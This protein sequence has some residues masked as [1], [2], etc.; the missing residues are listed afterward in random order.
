MRGASRILLALARRYEG[1]KAGRTGAAGRPVMVDYEKFLAESECADG[2]ARQAAEHDLREAAGR[3]LLKLVPHRRDPAIMESIRFEHAEE[4]ALFSAVGLASPAA[5]RAAI[6]G[7]FRQA[8]SHPIPENFRTYWIDYLRGKE[9]AALAGDSIAPFDR[10]DPNGNLEL[11]MLVPKLLAW[12]EES[13]VRFASCVL[14]GNSKRLEELAPRERTGEFAGQLRGKLGRVL[15][16]I[17]SGAISSLDDLGIR[18]TPR[19]ALLHGPLQLQLAGEVLNLGVLAGPVR[20]SQTDI[21]AAETIGTTASICLTVENETSFHE[22]AKLRSN[23][24]L[25]CTTFPGSATLA[26]LRR[27]P[28]HLQFW[29][30]GDSDGAG[31]EILETLRRKSGRLFRPFLMCRDRSNFEQESLGRP[32]LP[33]W[34]FYKMASSARE[35]GASSGGKGN[36]DQR[37]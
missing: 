25:I 12:R 33:S 11:L 29:H 27:L 21:D 8:T 24:L 23:V 2:E 7:Q 16:E 4:A 15:A 1:S 20:L 35:G 37:T 3:G 10:S 19:S 32:D 6:A 14:C 34:P 26:L 18:A 13:L 36:S 5:S 30:F 9:N 31:F 17:T 28:S 22:L